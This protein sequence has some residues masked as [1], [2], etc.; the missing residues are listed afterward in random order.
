MQKTK[1]FEKKNEKVLDKSKYFYTFAP[2]L[3]IMLGESDTIHQRKD[4]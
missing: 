1:C 2:H 4:G 3:R